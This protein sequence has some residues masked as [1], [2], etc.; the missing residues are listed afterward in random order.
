MVGY[1]GG[2]ARKRR[3]NFIFFLIF[4][5]FSLFIYYFYPYLET[6]EAKPSD[7]LIPSEDEMVKPQINSTI[8]ELN[9]KGP[10]N[11]FYVL[12]KDLLTIK[13]FPFPP[14]G[15]YLPQTAYRI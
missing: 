1:V 6:E 5:I 11:I 7:K 14:E 10:R 15:H 2:R 4:L 8:E 9:S 3:R 13:F 12:D